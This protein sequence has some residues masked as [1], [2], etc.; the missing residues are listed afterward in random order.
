MNIPRVSVHFNNKDVVIA[1]HEQVSEILEQYIMSNANSFLGFT[2]TNENKV[3]MENN[4]NT[5][6]MQLNNAGQLFK[7]HNNL[8]DVKGFLWVN[9][10]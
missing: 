7:N 4:I 9:Y 1:I 3:C 6:L 2:A 10:E 8:W 5:K